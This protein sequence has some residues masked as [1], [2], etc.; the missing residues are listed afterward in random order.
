VW[1]VAL[2]VAFLIAGD[3][4]SS[5]WWS[6][7]VALS[8]SAVVLNALSLNLHLVKQIATT[9]QTLLVLTHAVVVIGTFVA[10]WRHHESKLAMI[11]QMFPGFACAAFMD[12]YPEEKRVWTSRIFFSFNLLGLVAMQTGLA[13]NWL[14]VNDV[15]FEPFG[16]WSFKLSEVCASSTSSLIPFALRNLWAT[17]RR[18]ETLAVH[19][20]SVV[21]LKMDEPMF[22]LL[23]AVH[24]FLTN[25]AA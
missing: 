2:L 22:R 10:L 13:F 12:A 21:C 6:W 15:T 18:P 5:P 20:C 7:L 4:L 16:G 8:H 14:A 25:G 3:R 11:V 9:F 23:L 24:T 19:Q 17:Y 1:A